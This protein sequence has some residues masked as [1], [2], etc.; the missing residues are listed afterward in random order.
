MWKTVRVPD[1]KVMPG[2]GTECTWGAGQGNVNAS[3]ELVKGHLKP[4]LPTSSRSCDD[5]L[6]HSCDPLDN[7]GQADIRIQAS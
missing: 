7:P 2:V 4:W 5:G 1:D 3:L 6:G